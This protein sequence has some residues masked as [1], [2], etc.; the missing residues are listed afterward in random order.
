MEIL[1]I[2]IGVVMVAA[3]TLFGLWPL[4]KGKEGRDEDG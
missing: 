4:P 1:L 2:V 3:I